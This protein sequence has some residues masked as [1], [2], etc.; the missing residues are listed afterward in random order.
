[1]L[2]H[3]SIDTFVRH[4]SVGIHVDAQAIVRGLP[5]QKQLMR[6]ACSMSRSI[7][8]R[9]PYRL[10]D[11]SCINDIPRVRTLEERKQVRKRT[12]DA[13]KRAYENAQGALQ[14]DFGDDPPKKGSVSH[15]R[16]DHK[17]WKTQKKGVEKLRQKYQRAEDL[18]DHAVKQLRNE[19]RRQKH[20]LIRENFERYLSFHTGKV[21]NKEVIGML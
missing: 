6:F 3:A 11:T 13:K 2:Q 20:R 21:V 19:K 4:Y 18:H 12:R 10:E 15:F 7:D 8:P 9:R 1:M 17:Q 14:R 16:I 5:A